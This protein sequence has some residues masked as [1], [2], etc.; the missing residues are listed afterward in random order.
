MD[1]ICKIT[2]D[3]VGDKCKNDLY[4]LSGFI[5]DTM[6]N[7]LVGWDIPNR[8][9]FE[10][11]TRYEEYEYD[12]DKVVNRF[13]KGVIKNSD[14]KIDMLAYSWGG[15]VAQEYARRYP[16]DANK[17][18]FVNAF[19]KIV[20]GAETSAVLKLLGETFDPRVTSNIESIERA[21]SYDFLKNDIKTPAL[22]YNCLVDMAIGGIPPAIKGMRS[23]TEACRHA[24]TRPDEGG[25]ISA[26]VREFLDGS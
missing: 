2:Q 4:F 10:C 19:G 15:F 20:A 12:L 14:G 23:V 16:E 22:S 9:I 13:R 11:D 24:H 1:N 6:D 17:I 7:Q 3:C 8:R 25:R 5:T 18:V 21:L 26:M